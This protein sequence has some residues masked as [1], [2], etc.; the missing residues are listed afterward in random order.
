MTNLFA[1][2]TPPMKLVLAFL[3]TK[4]GEEQSTDQN[5]GNIRSSKINQD[6]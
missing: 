6:N 3:I 5:K 1:T 4:Y 2:S